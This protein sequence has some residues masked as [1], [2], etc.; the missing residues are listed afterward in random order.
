MVP[1]LPFVQ[2]RR[3]RRLCAVVLCVAFLPACGSDSTCATCSA[4]PADYDVFY[5]GSWQLTGV[6]DQWVD[7]IDNV[8][9]PPTAQEA[10]T[11]HVF[12]SEDYLGD[13][14]SAPVTVEWADR[15]GAGNWYLWEGDVRVQAT[16][17][18][19]SGESEVYAATFILST[20]SDTTLGLTDNHGYFEFYGKVGSP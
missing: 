20:F 6:I 13:S 19:P 11:W 15:T 4:S 8:P 14:V 12:P 18:G 10:R 7:T 1:V 17:T 9:R 5:R 2:F 3:A 16:L